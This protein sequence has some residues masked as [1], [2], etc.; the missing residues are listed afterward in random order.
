VFLNYSIYLSIATDLSSIILMPSARDVPNVPVE[1]ESSEADGNEEAR[2]RNAHTIAHLGG[3]IVKSENFSKDFQ[4]RPCVAG[5]SRID[6]TG[7]GR[8]VKLQLTTDHSPK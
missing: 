7:C 1:G 6:R 5:P 2:L 4:R 3:Q 8:A